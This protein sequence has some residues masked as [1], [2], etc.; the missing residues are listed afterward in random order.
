MNDAS[1][2]TLILDRITRYRSKY[3]GSSWISDFMSSN[4]RDKIDAVIARLSTILTE[5]V[6]GGWSRVF[7]RPVAAT[8]V[9]I[10]WSIDSA[11]EQP[12]IELKVSDGR[13]SYHLGQ[14]SLG[15]RWY[16]SFL[17]FTRFGR[18]RKRQ[19]I[20]LFDEPAANL[21]AK[22]QSELL[23]TFSRLSENGD[24]V[25]YSTHSH[26]MVEPRWLSSAY[27]VENEAIDYEKD[28]PAGFYARDTNIKITQYR[29]FVGQN[30]SRVSYFQPVLDR[31]H[32][33]EGALTP[34]GRQIMLEG[35]S[36]FFAFSYVLQRLKPKL[37]INVIP[38]TGSGSLDTL[39]SLAL[40]RGNRFYV[41]LDDDESGRKNAD[42][43]RQ[44]FFLT[45]EHVGTIADV[46][47]QRANS[48]LEDLLSDETKSKVVEQFGNK[49]KASIGQYLAE[50]CRTGAE[51]ALSDETFEN[52][53]EIL[54]KLDA[55][56]VQKVP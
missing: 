6:I 54:R 16:F 5:E 15:F 46:I 34:A 21:H 9:E 47:P 39:V 31:L 8:R 28:D 26:H 52:L 53:A 40:A 48:A 37:E 27:I 3:K 22:A 18:D 24:I 4:E 2:K 19:N 36:D 35:P 44:K 43:Y 11:I 1:L 55:E 56:L 17:L 33:F 13:S 20:F 29:S 14:R 42:R 49:K 38:G 32:Y 7:N 25:V 45:E 10:K 12:Y 23:S 50:Q 30:G 51:G 41:L